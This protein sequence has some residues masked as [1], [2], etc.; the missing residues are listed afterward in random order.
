[1]IT[2]QWRHV[3][4]WTFSA[5][6][7]KSQPF[8]R[9]VIEDKDMLISADLMSGQTKHAGSMVIHVRCYVTH[10]ID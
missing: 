7:K 6:T 4:E 3:I 1:M 9:S 10:V 5:T 2:F 8:N